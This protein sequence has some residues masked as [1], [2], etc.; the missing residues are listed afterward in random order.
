[1]RLIFVFLLLMILAVGCQQTPTKVY[2]SQPVTAKEATGEIS[3][4]EQ[5]VIIDARPAF[6]YTVSHLNGAIHLR[7]EEFN[8]KETPFQGI[9]DPDY[10][11]SARRL[12]RLGISPETPVVVVGRGPQGFG[13]EGRMAWTLK[14]FGVKDVKFAAI[15]YFS[16]PLSTAEAPPRKNAVIWK[17]VIDESLEIS[18]NEF[19]N[20]VKKPRADAS[21]AVIIDVRS[22]E[23]YLGKKSNRKDPDIGAINIPWVEFFTPK[24]LPHET[25]RSRLESVGITRDRK[26]LTISERG[27]ESAAVTL[28]LRELGY[29]KATNFSGGYWQLTSG[30]KK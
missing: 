28:A 10:F 25:V 27:I 22:S 11:A 4:T 20:E 12:A 16:L 14:F 15:D 29:S 3:I 8:Q 5:T 7:P 19:L 24:G 18:K 26:I 1:M 2:Q 30:N 21:S 13:E 9:L 6:E 17:P 23:A